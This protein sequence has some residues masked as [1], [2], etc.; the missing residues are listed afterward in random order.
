MTTESKFNIEAR[1]SFSIAKLSFQYNPESSKLKM[2]EDIRQ[3]RQ[4]ANITTPDHD[5]TNPISKLPSSH[6]PEPSDIE[7]DEDIKSQSTQLANIAT[8]G[9][10]LLQSPP[11]PMCMPSKPSILLPLYIYPAPGA[12]VPLYKAYAPLTSIVSDT[13][14]LT[15]PQ[16]LKQPL[17]PLHNNHQPP[18]WSRRL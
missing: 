12:W 8:P 3:L 7:K 1:K 15:T 9:E 11:N 10:T 2:D 5:P 4:L 17:S 13:T 18:Q 16:N 6:N 14:P